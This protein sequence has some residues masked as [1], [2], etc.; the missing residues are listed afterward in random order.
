MFCWGEVARRRSRAS[1]RLA[2]LSSAQAAIREA[3][4][5]KETSDLN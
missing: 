2:L 4:P 5:S 3:A 1:I